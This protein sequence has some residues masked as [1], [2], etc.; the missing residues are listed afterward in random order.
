MKLKDPLM[1]GKGNLK[2]AA[3]LAN[4]C[5]QSLLEDHKK[6]YG[7]SLVGPESEEWISC[8]AIVKAPLYDRVGR[9]YL[10][11]NQFRLIS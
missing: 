5:M 4:E 8:E 1:G 6:K 7:V 3:S 10:R 11:R 9:N 2:T